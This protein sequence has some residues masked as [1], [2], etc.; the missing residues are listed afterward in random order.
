MSG[1]TPLYKYN[2]SRIGLIVHKDG[3]IDVDRS[4][5]STAIHSGD[6]DDK[7]QVVKNFTQQIFRKTNQIS[8]NPMR[9]VDKTVVAYKNPGHNFPT[10]YVSSNY[11]GM[12]FNYYC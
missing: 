1:I 11:I 5:L 3:S 6:A 7:F 10:P 4:T 9:Y 8:L 2:L 12:L